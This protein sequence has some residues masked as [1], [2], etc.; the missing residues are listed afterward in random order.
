MLFRSNV[1][2]SNHPHSLITQNDRALVKHRPVSPDGTGLGTDPPLLLHFLEASL[3][4][5][6]VNTHTHTRE[7]V[8]RC[9][10]GSWQDLLASSLPVW[11]AAP[12]SGFQV[13][14]TLQS[15]LTCGTYYT[16]TQMYMYNM[17][18]IICLRL[19]YVYYI[20]MYDM[21]YTVLCTL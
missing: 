10:T 1:P 13:P 9:N 8:I 6:T 21:M 4:S 12:F 7:E 20:Q 5:Q 16:C 14:D 3:Q 11:P 19:I 15:R 18:H 17:T 2:R